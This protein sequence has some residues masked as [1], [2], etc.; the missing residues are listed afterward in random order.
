MCLLKRT[1]GTPGTGFNWLSSNCDT[2]RGSHRLCGVR[3]LWAVWGGEREIN[4]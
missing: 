1:S 4:E 3:D 2:T